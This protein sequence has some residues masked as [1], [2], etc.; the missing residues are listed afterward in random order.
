M[1]LVL[2]QVGESTE[3]PFEGGANDVPMAYLSRQIEIDMMSLIGESCDLPA[4]A[5]DRSIVL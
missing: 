5:P 3:N 2:E 1:Y 4:K